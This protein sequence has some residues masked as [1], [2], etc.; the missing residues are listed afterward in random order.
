MKLKS[1]LKPLKAIKKFAKDGEFF[2]F[3]PVV[4][5][6]VTLYGFEQ[7]LYTEDNS[8]EQTKIIGDIC[9]ESAFITNY[10]DV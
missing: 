4:I 7:I 8:G 9:K 5:S 6:S 1:L 2:T 10:N 3:V